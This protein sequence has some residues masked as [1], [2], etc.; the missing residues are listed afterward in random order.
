MQYRVLLESYV[1][2]GVIGGHA[3]DPFDMFVIGDFSGV[4]GDEEDEGVKRML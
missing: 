2:S 4:D 3:K 1:L